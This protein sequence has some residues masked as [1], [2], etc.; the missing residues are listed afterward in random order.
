MQCSVRALL[1]LTATLC[2]AGPGQAFQMHALVTPLA[3]GQFHYDVSVINDEVVDVIL[4][5]ISDAPL[6]DVNITLSLTGPAGYGAV[7][8]PILGF[9]DFVE[10]TLLFAASTT[11]EFFS[12]DTA[13]G[14]GLGFFDSFEAFTVNADLL[15]GTVDTT[16]V[17]EPGTL[18]L[19]GLGL[20]SIAARRR[21]TRR[22]AR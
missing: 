14:P 2:L 1:A 22:T 21:T 15:T 7:Y 5:S 19:L 16:V 8:D 20:C 9:L 17:P 3:G 18:A 4:A 6:G 12:F 13:T 11:T 10:D